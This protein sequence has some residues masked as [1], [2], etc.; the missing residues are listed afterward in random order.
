MYFL[1]EHTAHV[2]VTATPFPKHSKSAIWSCAVPQV[3][4]AIKEYACTA[5]DV[6]ARRTRLGFLNVQAA[7]EALPRIVEIMAKEL[8]WSEQRSQVTSD[9]NNNRSSTLNLVFFLLLKA[10]Y[11]RGRGPC[12]NLHQCVV[13]KGLTTHQL[14]AE[15][16]EIYGQLY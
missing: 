9:N 12:N 13:P 6:I 14:H 1:C 2:A 8:G 5:I 10:L 3:L 7:D 11:K 15:S 4:Y 16:E